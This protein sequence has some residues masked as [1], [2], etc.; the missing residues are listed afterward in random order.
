MKKRGFILTQAGCGSKAFTLAETLITLSIIGVV[1]ALTM[2]TLISN[3]REKVIL[4]RLKKAVSVFSQAVQRSFIDNGSVEDWFEG[5]SDVSAFYGPLFTTYFKPYVNTIK[6]CDEGAAGCWAYHTKLMN[7]S[8][9]SWGNNKFGSSVYLFVTNDGMNVTIDT[10]ST[11]DCQNN[12][13]AGTLA[14][15]SRCL[16]LAVDVNGMQSPNMVGKDT[17]FFVITDKGLVPAGAGSNFAN[18]SESSTGYSCAAKFL[19]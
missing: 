6:E 11:A 10:W 2:P 18:C 17:F 12:F 4:T 14:A 13:N 5:Y 9:N 3:Y 16:V 8:N 7:G 19:Q 1:A 15:I